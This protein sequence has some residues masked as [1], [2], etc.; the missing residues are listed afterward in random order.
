M[1]A[2]EDSHESL[3]QQ[4][5]RD[6][7]NVSRPAVVHR[8]FFVYADHSL[9]VMIHNSVPLHWTSGGTWKNQLRQILKKRNK[10]GPAVS[11]ELWKLYC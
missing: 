6:Q 2:C 1:N 7:N 9:P 8:M 5:G 4:K 11:C 3:A 10:C